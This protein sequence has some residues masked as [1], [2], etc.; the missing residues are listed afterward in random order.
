MR[1]SAVNSTPAIMVPAEALA[2]HGLL[3]TL[4][5]CSLFSDPGHVFVLHVELG[6]DKFRAQ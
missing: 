1:N 3:P 4:L 6:A 5:S 2:G